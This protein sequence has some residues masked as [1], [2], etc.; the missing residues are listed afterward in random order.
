M[1][2]LEVAKYLAPYCNKLLELKKGM[3]ETQ[4]DMIETHKKHKKTHARQM[5]TLEQLH[6]N[7]LAGVQHLFEWVDQEDEG[8]P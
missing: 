7:I 1:T 6:E 2:A 8:K 5:E 3:V 4:N